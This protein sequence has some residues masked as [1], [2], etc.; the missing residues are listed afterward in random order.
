MKVI[1]I[2]D[3]RT[4][5]HNKKLQEG[6]KKK[7]TPTGRRRQAYANPQEVKQ[8][9]LF[10]LFPPPSTLAPT[11]LTNHKHA[12]PVKECHRKHMR[13]KLSTEGTGREN[14]IIL[15]GLSVQI[16]FSIL[17]L[18]P[19]AC[20]REIPYYSAPTRNLIWVGLVRSAMRFLQ[21]SLLRAPPPVRPSLLSKEQAPSPP[22]T[23]STTYIDTYIHTTSLQTSCVE[24][25][26]PSCGS[27]QE[28][29]LYCC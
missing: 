2:S 11:P 16:S 15:H 28:T 27:Q 6:K 25:H 21:E 19:H 7:K 18:F 9:G 14:T 26:L 3:Q 29:L 1:G 17:P 13:R 24:Q 5:N 12:T 22:S 23:P 8:N 10:L 20:K 4:G